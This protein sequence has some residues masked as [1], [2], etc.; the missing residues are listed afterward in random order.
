MTTSY[1]SF[2]T[3]IGNFLGN[4]FGCGTYFGFS[5]GDG[6]GNGDSKYPINLIL[7]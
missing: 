2:R 1:T 4:G 3:N 5:N 7:Y 6:I